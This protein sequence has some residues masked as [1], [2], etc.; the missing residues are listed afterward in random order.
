MEVQD[1]T[2]ALAKSIIAD[3]TPAEPRGEFP[4]LLVGGNIDLKR[5]PVV[6]NPDGTISTVRSI[7]VGTDDGEVLIPTVSDDGRVLS[8]EEAIQLFRQTGKHLGVFASPGAATAYA[9]ALHGQQAAFY[10]D[11]Q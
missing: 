9:E 1:R 11:R 3:L 7:S 6:R 5:R 10:G 2:H 8:D 4:G